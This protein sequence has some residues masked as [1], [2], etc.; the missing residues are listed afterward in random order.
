MLQK[1]PFEKIDNHIVAGHLVGIVEH[2]MPFIGEDE[3][4]ASTG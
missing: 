4:R 3:S 2:V 1:M